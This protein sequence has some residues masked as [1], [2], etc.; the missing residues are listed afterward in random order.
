MGLDPHLV[1][2]TPLPADA[3]WVTPPQSPSR[4]CLRNCVEDSEAASEPGEG[5]SAVIYPEC[6]PQARDLRPATRGAPAPFCAS[7]DSALLRNSSPHL[8]VRQIDE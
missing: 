4:G 5:E 8:L 2:P 6:L 7:L 1:C 3:I